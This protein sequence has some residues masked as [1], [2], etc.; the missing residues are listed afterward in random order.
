MSNNLKAKFIT[1]P[2]K[3][4]ALII[5]FMILLRFAYLFY[6]FIQSPFHA[7]QLSAQVQEL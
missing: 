4:I 1:I 5:A 2:V 7:L 6:D 3:I